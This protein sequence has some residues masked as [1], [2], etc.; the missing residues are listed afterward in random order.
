MSAEV[1]YAIPVCNLCDAPIFTLQ[2]AAQT[3][4]MDGNATFTVAV[5]GVPTIALQWQVSIDSGVSWT[6]LSDNAIYGGAT[7]TTLAINASPLSYNN[8][9]YRCVAVNGCGT[10]YSTAAMLTN[11]LTGHTYTG[12]FIW[13]GT[14]PLDGSPG[15][16][17]NP[18]PL[19]NHPSVLRIPTRYLIRTALGFSEMIQ[20]PYGPDGTISGGPHGTIGSVTLNNLGGSIV[21]NAITGA[22]TGNYAGQLTYSGNFCT[23]S[24]WRGSYGG[25]TGDITINVSGMTLESML[26]FYSYEIIGPLGKTCGTDDYPSPGY[27]MTYCGNGIWGNPGDF[28]FE[29]LTGEGTPSSAATAGGGSEVAFTGQSS[30]SSYDPVTG[31]MAGTASV[32]NVNRSRLSVTGD[33][34]VTY[35]YSAVPIGGGT[36]QTF[37]ESDTVAVGVGNP[38]ATTKVVPMLPGYTVSITDIQ[39]AD[40]KD[41]ADDFSTYPLGWTRTLGN[42]IGWSA[43]GT[44]GMSQPGESADSF[45]TLTNGITTAITSGDNWIG[46]GTFGLSETTEAWDDFGTYANGTI[47]LVAAGFGWANPGVFGE[48]DYLQSYDDFSGFTNGSYDTLASTGIIWIADGTFGLEDY[49]I[50]SDDFSSY[51]NGSYSTLTGGT[52]WAAAGTFG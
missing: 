51:A 20:A 17:I 32:V 49:L 40:L 23:G 35:S 18:A 50:A 43:T 6:N 4:D 37:S 1:T 2:P 41:S 39:V 19:P 15:P 34:I 47:N 3:A 31:A 48:N 9:R 10:T 24:S 42:G 11:A 29:T 25:Y 12:P 38:L 27:L 33:F 46:P 52:N 21:T 5:S 13:H 8:N 22:V 26:P 16:G 45:D 28:A 44:F 36:A 30:V 14:P 7:T